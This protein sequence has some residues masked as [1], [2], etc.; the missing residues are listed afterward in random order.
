VTDEELREGLDSQ[1]IHFVLILLVNDFILKLDEDCYP[2]N[3]MDEVPCYYSMESSF[4]SLLWLLWTLEKTNFMQ[5]KPKCFIVL[6]NQQLQYFIHALIYYVCLSDVK[7]FILMIT[8]IKMEYHNRPSYYFRLFL[9]LSHYKYNDKGTYIFTKI[10]YY[11]ISS[12]DIN[13]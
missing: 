9:D 12:I 2:L 6:V 7:K 10:W 3:S 13:S 4:T 11:L 5:A 8:L 1:F